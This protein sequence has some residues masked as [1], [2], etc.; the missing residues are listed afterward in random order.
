MATGC[1]SLSVSAVSPS[2]PQVY[3][4]IHSASGTWKGP[5]GTKYLLFHVLSTFSLHRTETNCA[6]GKCYH[7]VDLLPLFGYLLLCP[8][9]LKP[10]FE[11]ARVE[12]WGQRTVVCRYLEE[13][14]KPR[15]KIR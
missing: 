3:R 15:I 6:I 7:N 10:S 14:Y 5:S 1:P 9:I 2:S 13:D 8:F 12:V 4:H 11:A